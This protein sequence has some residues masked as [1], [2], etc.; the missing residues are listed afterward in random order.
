MIYEMAV[1]A[2]I[3]QTVIEDLKNIKEL[4]IRKLLLKPK[5]LKMLELLSKKIKF[6]LSSRFISQF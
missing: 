2:V 5:L 3:S 6:K 1:I 4:S